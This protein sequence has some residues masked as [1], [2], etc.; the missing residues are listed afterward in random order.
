MLESDVEER[1]T[2]QLEFVLE[3]EKLKQIFRQTVL[4]GDER[5]ENDAEHSWHLGLMAVLLVEHAKEPEVDLLR[6]VKMVLIHDLVE[7]DAGDTFA[8]DEAGNVDKVERE[9]VAAERIFGLLSEDQKRELRSL[10]DEFEARQTPEA[11]Y[12][13][14]LDRLQPVMLN[15]QTQGAAWRRHGVTRAQVIAR[16]KHISEG[17]PSLWKY[18]EGLI[19]EAVKRGYLAG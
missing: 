9:T 15:F 16:N 18:A 5:R 12:A 8:Y 6:V 11:R 3:V 14:A 2:R 13:A 17:S 7:I 19:D 4:P 10:W 1:L